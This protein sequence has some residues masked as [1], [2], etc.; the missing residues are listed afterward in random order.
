MKKLKFGD[1]N[2][3]NTQVAHPRVNNRVHLKQEVNF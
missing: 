1:T 2:L 3:L